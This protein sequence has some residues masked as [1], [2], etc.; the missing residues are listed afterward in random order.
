MSNND[1]LQHR[2]KRLEKSVSE[3][4]AAIGTLEHWV[5]SRATADPKGNRGK[6]GAPLAEFKR[7]LASARESLRQ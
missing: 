1:D 4:L 2:V 6:W 5:T 3:L 7:L